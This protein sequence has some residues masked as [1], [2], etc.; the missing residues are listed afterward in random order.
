VADIEWNE[1]GFR[2]LEENLNRELADLTVLSE[3]EG[4]EEDA[5]RDLT[6]QYQSKGLEPDRETVVQIVRQ[7]RQGEARPCTRVTWCAP[8]AGN[9]SP[10]RRTAV[11][12]VTS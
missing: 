2:E 5:I 3:S 12:K 4:S 7:A 11:L 6:A 8:P 10:R 9:G 1:E